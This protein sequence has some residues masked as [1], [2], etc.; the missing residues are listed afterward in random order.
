MGGDKMSSLYEQWI[1]ITSDFKNNNFWDKFSHDEKEIYKQLLSIDESPILNTLQNFSEKFN[2]DIL[3]M[4]GFVI[5]IN[6]SLKTPN[7]IENIEKDTIITLDYDAERLYKNLKNAGYDLSVFENCD[8]SNINII[9]IVN[10]ILNSS[11]KKLFYY[12]IYINDD[13]SSK[14]VVRKYCDCNDVELKSII[15]LYLQEYRK[16]PEIIQAN[17]I[18]KESQNKPKC[19]TC[20]SADVK[21]IGSG[22]RTLSV[23]TF[24][25]L[26]NKINKSFKCLNCKYTW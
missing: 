7:N 14:Q 18:A 24:G 17:A 16:D 1:K 21:P 9:K 10:Q 8:K 22:E 3:T 26:S 23:I 5:G 4:F 20:G 15:D 19:P 2:V 11:D 6:D 12:Y 25:L 13:I